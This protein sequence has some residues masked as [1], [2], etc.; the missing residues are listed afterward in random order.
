MKIPLAEHFHSIQG[1]GTYVGTPM[2]FIR[3]P[4]C[5]VG[6]LGVGIHHNGETR[7]EQREEDELT[8]HP[9]LPTRKPAWLCHTWNNKP[10]WCD[11]DFSKYGEE[12]LDVL[13]NETWEQHICL[14]G[15]E[16][17]IHREIVNALRTQCQLRGFLLHIET[18]GT[19]DYW[20]EA[21]ELDRELDPLR[22]WITVSPKLGFTPYMVKRA[23]ELKLLVGWDFDPKTLDMSFLEHPNVFVSPINK[24]DKSNLDS[25]IYTESLKGLQ[26]AQE[27]LRE[28]PNWRLSVQLHK[29]LGVR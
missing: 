12:E 6:K 11:T 5:S 25:L 29:Y 21:D 17:L 8:P 23:D 20:W 28:Y 4:G 18:S 26:R 2:H 19:I 15:G 9:T 16:P 1:E 10:F 13:L 27:L 7:I 22:P 24:V 14:T 3:L